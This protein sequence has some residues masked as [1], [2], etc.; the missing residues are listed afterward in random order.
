MV[1]ANAPKGV[2][3]QSVERAVSALQVFFEEGSPLSVTGVVAKT[4]LASATVHRLL[5]TLVKTG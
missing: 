3:V 5:S 2:T 4:G 1:N